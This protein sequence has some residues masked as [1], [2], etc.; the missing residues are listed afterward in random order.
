M[1]I[2]CM[3]TLIQFLVSGI[4]FGVWVLFDKTSQ[5]DSILLHMPVLNIMLAS[6]LVTFVMLFPTIVV[7]SIFNKAADLF[8]ESTVVRHMLFVMA[9]LIVF[10]LEAW[11]ITL[12]GQRIAWYPT[13]SFTM[14]FT[15]SSVSSIVIVVINR[16][17]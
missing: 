7:T 11:A 10:G 3:K 16:I 15:Y 9:I 17:Y 13:M 1:Y 5:I 12:L 8:H 2:K 14:G 6:V 4:L